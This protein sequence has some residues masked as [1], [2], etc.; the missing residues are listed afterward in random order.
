MTTQPVSGLDASIFAAVIER[1]SVDSRRQLALELARHISDPA[2]VA[3]ERASAV[4]SALKLA[5]DPVEDVRQALVT[6]L[7]NAK[8]LDADLLFT[9]VADDDAI[10]LP[11]LAAT[12][13]LD[14][15]RTIAVLRAGDMARQI[16]IASRP[17]LASS[18]IDEI[19]DA[20]CHEACMAL[21]DNV[22][23]KLEGDHCRR[24]Y[25]RFGQSPDIVE[26]LIARPDLPLEIRI[27]QTKRA[28]NRIHQLMAERG[29][30]A[31]N[32]AAEVVADAEESAIL[33]I[34]VNATKEELPRVISFLTTKKMLMPSIILRA[35]C[36][37]EMHVVERTLAHLANL[38]LPKTRQQMYGGGFSAFKSLH[39]KSGL[40]VGSLGLLK[41]AA[42]VSHEAREEGLR[43]GCESFGRR[44]IEALM[45]RYESLPLRERAKH[46]EFIG[47]FA[48]DRVRVIA[49]RL[50]TNLM[51]AA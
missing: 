21:L 27:L 22:D 49:K 20:R 40:P 7:S 4:P 10:A 34:L 28:S 5:I 30:V 44:L 36:L 13:A 43:I 33:H 45:T 17:G 23:A 26:R 18:V 16:T 11:F 3:A 8:Q 14:E 29:W 42:D 51:H 12:P 19:V 15:F 37:G 48:D 38:P 41:A 25:V 46:L 6:G 32:D 24:L 2:T 9:I 47:R 35:A 31:A 50:K 39:A 1:G